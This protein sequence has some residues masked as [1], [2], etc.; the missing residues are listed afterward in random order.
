MFRVSNGFGTEY[1]HEVNANEYREQVRAP[2]THE[3]RDVPRRGALSL[4]QKPWHFRGI[5][6]S[7]CQ[8]FLVALSPVV[9]QP[10]DSA[11]EF[12]RA[13][14]LAERQRAHSVAHAGLEVEERRA[15]N[16]EADWI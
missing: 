4:P 5:Q 6:K 8:P 9:T 1:D 16:F 2:Y 14:E 11:H 7:S 12:F 10:R 3:P 15:G 13:E